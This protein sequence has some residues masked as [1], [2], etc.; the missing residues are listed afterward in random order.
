MQLTQWTDYSLRVLMYCAQNQEREEPI[1]IAEIIERHQLS[2]SHVTKIVS[3]LSSV[4][5]LNTTRGRNGGIT[6]AQPAEKINIG[7][8]VRLTETNFNIVECF[9]KKN[10]TCKIINGCKL[11]HHLFKA[12]DNFLK[13][14]DNVTLAQIAS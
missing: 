14:L 10:N 8:V 12:A 1:T 6:L 13:T 11:K 2:K 7:Q 3:Y 9:D 5:L 4:G